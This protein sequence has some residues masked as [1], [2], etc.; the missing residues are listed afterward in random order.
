MKTYELTQSG[1]ITIEHTQ[2]GDTVTMNLLKGSWFYG[3]WHDSQATMNLG[4]LV[5]ENGYSIP[6]CPKH[7]FKL[8]EA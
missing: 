6:M 4:E 8:K 3:E 2:D 5:L 7:L 1:P